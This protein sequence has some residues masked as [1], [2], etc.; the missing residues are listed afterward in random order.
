MDRMPF[1]VRWRGSG[2][3]YNSTPITRPMLD[4][5]ID[6]PRQRDRT[7]DGGEHGAVA[8]RGEEVRVLENGARR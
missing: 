5:A 6:E 4:P 2:Q 3:W 7:G 1:F 8:L